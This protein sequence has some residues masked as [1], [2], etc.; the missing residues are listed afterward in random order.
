V[1]RD[2][3]SKTPWYVVKQKIEKIGQQSGTIRF[4]I[5][6]GDGSTTV[7]EVAVT[8]FGFTR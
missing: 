3:D 8:S 5:R 4:H 7:R 1:D 2:A 6:Y